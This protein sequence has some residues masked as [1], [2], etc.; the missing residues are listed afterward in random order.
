MLSA[1]GLSASAIRVCPSADLEGSVRLMDG[2][3]GPGYE[4]G[5]LEIFVRG[6]W[7]TVC[8]KKGF[9]PDS[10]L[11]ACRALG[12]EGGTVLQFTQAYSRGRASL[13]NEVR[14]PAVP[15]HQLLFFCYAVPVAMKPVTPLR[16]QQRVFPRMYM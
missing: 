3:S 6:F 5:R 7:S 16:P 15:C 4:Y 12:Y 8:D 11:V 2:S 9:T 14:R 13:E 10:A 1:P